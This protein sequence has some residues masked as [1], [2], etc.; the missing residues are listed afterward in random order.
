[1][2]ELEPSFLLG[3]LNYHIFKTLQ[4]VNQFFFSMQNVSTNLKE[5]LNL[6]KQDYPLTYYQPSTNDILIDETL[7]S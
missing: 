2:I 4:R 6:L 5:D 1:M 3:L 7:V